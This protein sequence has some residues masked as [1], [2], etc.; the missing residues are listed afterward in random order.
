MF[1]YFNDDVSAI[2]RSGIDKALADLA[3]R[4]RGP[5]TYRIL[6]FVVGSCGLDSVLLT[7][8]SIL[9]PSLVY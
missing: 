2:R 6:K 3:A 4:K 5:Q 9:D 7:E 8:G 1:M